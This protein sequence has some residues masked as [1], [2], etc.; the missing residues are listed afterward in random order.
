MQVS[1]SIQ[2]TLSHCIATGTA[3]TFNFIISC[4]S[5]IIIRLY[6]QFTLKNEVYFSLNPS[7]S[8]AKGDSFP[9]SLP[10]NSCQCLN[11]LRWLEKSN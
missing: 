7:F 2:T 5:D 9:E 10:L 8:H 4:I 3:E 6:N 1:I 11:F